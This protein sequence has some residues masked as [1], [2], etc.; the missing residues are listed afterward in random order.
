[1]TMG[2]GFIRKQFATIASLDRPRR[3]EISSRDPVFEK[4]EQIWTFDPAADGGT[5]I[6]CR[7]ELRVRSQILQAVVGVSVAEG[8]KAMV[9]AYMRRAQRIYASPRSSSVNNQAQSGKCL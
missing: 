5:D 3:I 2:A 6:E 8:T 7:V 4:F 9:R 1:M